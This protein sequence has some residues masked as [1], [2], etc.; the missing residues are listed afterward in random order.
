MVGDM[1]KIVRTG[2]HYFCSRAC[3]RLLVDLSL[4]FVIPEHHRWTPC[5]PF[6]SGLVRGLMLL[7]GG[8]IL[9]HTRWLKEDCWIVLLRLVTRSK[10]GHV[11]ERG[12][13]QELRH[14]R[15]LPR[16]SV[17]TWTYVTTFCCVRSV[18]IEFVNLPDDFVS[19]LRWHVLPN[20]GHRVKET[21]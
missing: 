13:F 20:C 11:F 5:G 12:I 8:R 15:L 19:N 4:H 17:V 21:N 10:L 9:S 1:L 3:F 6:E 14:V 7:V 2:G 18:K 16:A